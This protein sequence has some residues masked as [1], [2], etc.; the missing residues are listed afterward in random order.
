MPVGKRKL[1]H[2]YHTVHF[3]AVLVSEQR[4]GL[5]VAHGQIAIAFQPVFVN[6]ELKRTGH[7]S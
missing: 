3:T 1:T 7:G 2:S 4:R 6:H 5:V